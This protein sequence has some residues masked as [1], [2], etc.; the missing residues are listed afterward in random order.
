MSAVYLLFC[1]LFASF[2]FATATGAKIC[3]DAYLSCMQPSASF[4]GD[5]RVALPSDDRQRVPR[6]A[7]SPACIRELQHFQLVTDIAPLA[8][9]LV[10]RT[11]DKCVREL[12]KVDNRRECIQSCLRRGGACRTI[13]YFEAHKNEHRMCDLYATRAAEDSL[14]LVLGGFFS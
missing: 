10:N 2:T 4:V 11:V 12:F 7:K 9:H 5:R 3:A 8:R 1:Y 14:V 6:Q 13:V